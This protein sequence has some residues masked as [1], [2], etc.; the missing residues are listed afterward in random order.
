MAVNQ[1]RDKIAAV[2]TLFDAP[3]MSEKGRQDIAAWLRR[4]ASFLLKHH[5]ELASRYTARYIYSPL[6]KK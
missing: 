6:K 4:Q 3:K 5:K 1:K 2:F